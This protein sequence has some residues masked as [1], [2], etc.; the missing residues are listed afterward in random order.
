VPFVVTQQSAARP[1]AVDP[2]SVSDPPGASAYVVSA[3]V[4]ASVTTRCPARSKVNPKGTGVADGLTT[5]DPVTEPDGVRLNTSM[6]LPLALVVTTRWRPSG[7][8]P[9]WPG[10]LRN[11]GVRP[12]VRPSDR[13]LPGTGVSE[14]A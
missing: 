4:A 2:S 8:K 3:L 14:S 6:S 13:L 9:I 12:G 10:V 1:S 11:A 5:G 7:V